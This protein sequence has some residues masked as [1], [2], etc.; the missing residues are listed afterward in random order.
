MEWERSKRP[1]VEISHQE[2]TSA[3][4]NV[5]YFRIA[6]S[7]VLLL[8]P[9]ENPDSSALTVISSPSSVLM[10]S[11]FTKPGS[12]TCLKIGHAKSVTGCAQARALPT[13]VSMPWTA[14]VA[15]HRRA[16][17]AR[18]SGVAS[19]SGWLIIAVV[20]A[21]ARARRPTGAGAGRERRPQSGG[22][23]VRQPVKQDQFG[24]VPHGPCLG[25]SPTGR[26]SFASSCTA[27]PAPSRHRS[28]VPRRPGSRAAARGASRPP[29][30][31]GRGLEPSPAAPARP[32]RPRPEYRAIRPNTP[33]YPTGRLSRCTSRRTSSTRCSS[34]VSASR[35]R[36]AVRP[37]PARP[38]RPRPTRRPNT[39]EYPR[40]PPNTPEYAHRS[41]QP[42]HI[43]KDIEKHSLLKLGERLASSPRIFGRGLEPP[44]TAA[45]PSPH[46][47]P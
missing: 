43:E 7:V 31:F 46:P 12:R 33:E 24:G 4:R 8:I 34:W 3:L 19:N 18:L 16:T 1:A 37:R 2:R 13:A 22:R 5:A 6:S 38:R 41:S 11:G 26:A 20:P 29:R 30:M 36:R 25:V 39:P 45:S 35:A 44:R 23:F 28:H 27:P 9:M 32:R 14:L 17:R 40:I 10:W 21:R 42:V 15:A 47:P